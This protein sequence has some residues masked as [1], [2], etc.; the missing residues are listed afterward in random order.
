MTARHLKYLSS[1]SASVRPRNSCV[2]ILYFP[3]APGITIF[4]SASQ[5]RILGRFDLSKMQ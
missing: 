3:S 5:P 2:S 4:P 1:T